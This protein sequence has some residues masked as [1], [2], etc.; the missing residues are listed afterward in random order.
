MCVCLHPLHKGLSGLACMRLG[1]VSTMILSTSA[2]NFINPHPNPD[3]CVSL[4]GK[5]KI[6]LQ[7]QS[8]HKCCHEEFHRI[9]EWFG[10]E[11]T[12]EISWFQPLPWPGPPS[13]TPD[14]SQPQHIQ[15]WGF[16]NFCEKPVPVSLTTLIV[17][18]LF[19]IPNLNPSYFTSESFLLVLSLCALE[20]VLLQISCSPF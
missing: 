14:C 16:H 19:L 9:I 20:K 6:S 3:G 1:Q 4:A 17:K 2:L 18:N 7:E 12:V 11:G 15:G 10:P 13:T 8:H 5:D